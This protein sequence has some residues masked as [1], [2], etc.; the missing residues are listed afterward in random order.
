MRKESLI[1]SIVRTPIGSFQGN[2]SSVPAVHLGAI[3]IQ[4][5]IKR[6]G[7]HTK[8]VDEVI[9]RAEKAGITVIINAGTNPETNKYTLKLSKKYIFQD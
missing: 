4:E 2:L 8:D 7:I 3:A 6:A 5:T 1:A 9:K